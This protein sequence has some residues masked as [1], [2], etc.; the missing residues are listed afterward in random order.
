MVPVVLIAAVGR[1]GEIGLRDGLPWRLPSDLRHFRAETMGK[2]VIM[3]RKT[4]ATLGRPLPGRFL[5]VVSRDPA[6]AV[7][8]GVESASSVGEA[9]LR[10][11][12][13]AAQRGAAEVMVAGGAEIYRAAL[14]RADALCLTE[15][16]LDPEAD[17]FFPA[18][19]P[20]LWR[21]VSRR[22]GDRAEADEADCEFVRWERMRPAEL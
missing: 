21:E 3:G 1:N 18:I 14:D 16:D 11:Q 9:L 8:E 12:A 15:V 2:P 20:K 4:F 19:D 13:I 17:S 10:G 7:P 5:I 6:L 22:S